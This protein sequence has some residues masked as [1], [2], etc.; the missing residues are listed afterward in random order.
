MKLT[1]LTRIGYVV[2]DFFF[3]RIFTVQATTKELTTSLIW[4]VFDIFQSNNGWAFFPLVG[5]VVILNKK[6]MFVPQA[7]YFFVP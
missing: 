1:T 5:M 4:S 6:V 7:D 3:C 2:I